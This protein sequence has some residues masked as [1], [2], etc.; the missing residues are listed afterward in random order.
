MEIT[1]GLMKIAPLLTAVVLAVPGL[2]ACGG[3]ENPKPAPLPTESRSA[4]S[5]P[6]KQPTLPANAASKTFESS[7]RWVIHYF[8]V[9][10]FAI[11]TGSTAALRSL[12]KP[13][14]QS[15]RAFARNI[16]RVYRNGGRIESNGWKITS[17]GTASAGPDHTNAFELHLRLT[18]ERVFRSQGGKPEVHPGVDHKVEATV[19]WE[20]GG[21]RMQE[22]LVIR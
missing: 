17:F 8:D 13:G 6:T 22:V 9:L 5:A 21:W 3:G 11:A 20:P 7:H 19:H 4:T 1:G 14:C 16:D 15:C 2:A 18:R 12:A 10:N